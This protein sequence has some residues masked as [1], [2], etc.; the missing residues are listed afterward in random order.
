MKSEDQKAYFTEIV[1]LYDFAE[2]IIDALERE[3]SKDPELEINLAKP[4]IDRFDICAHELAAAYKKFVDNGE[5]ASPAEVKKV[6]ESIR[7]VYM[8]ANKFIAH[9]KEMPVYQ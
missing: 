2:G 9:L 5:K 1:R 3:G 8:E 6:Q 7:K 4:V